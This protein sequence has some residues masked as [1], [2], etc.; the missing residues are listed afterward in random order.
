[1]IAAHGSFPRPAT[2]SPARRGI[3]RC[4]L[5]ALALLPCAA[6]AAP[7]GSPTPPPTPE[8][9]TAGYRLEPLPAGRPLRVGRWLEEVALLITDDERAR[10][11]ALAGDRQREAFVDDFW[12]R[13][14]PTPFT[15]DNE[16]RSRWTERVGAARRWAASAGVA[17][18]SDPRAEALLLAGR[19]RRIFELPCSD[20]AGQFPLQPLEI[21]Y[22][23][24]RRYRGPG[25]EPF[26]LVFILPSPAPGPP[27]A[28]R[29]EADSE[30]EAGSGPGHVRLWSPREGLAALL[31][32]RHRS[33]F[34]TDFLS[35]RAIADSADSGL[36]Y[37]GH[38][39][40]F[41][42]LERALHEGYDR[43]Q[44]LAL[45]ALPK[46]REAPA[47]GTIPTLAALPGTVDVAFAGEREEQTVVE[48]RLEL[49]RS[50][51]A[52]L[53]GREPLQHLTLT[54][55]L[56][57]DDAP[58]SHFLY[59]AYVSRSLLT[60]GDPQ[61]GE[62]GERGD[63]ATLPFLFYRTL[64]PGH[65][66]LKL[67][68]QEVESGTR[69]RS[70]YALWVPDLAAGSAAQRLPSPAGERRATLLSEDRPALVLR[71]ESLEILP[72]PPGLHLGTLAL[73]AAVTGRR[74]SYL[75][76]RLNGRPVGGHDEFP[77]GV[78]L[79]LGRRPRDHRVEAT[80]FD[81]AGQPVAYDR[82]EINAGPHRLR[83]RLI[84][85]QAGVRYEQTAPARVRVEVPDGATLDRVDLYLDD[86][87]VATS[88]TPPF[89]SE[90]PIPAPGYV[91]M[92][93]AVARLAD[94]RSADDGVLINSIEA[95]EEVEVDLV[96]LFLSAR[97]ELDQPVTDLVADDVAVF[98]D[99]IEQKVLRFERV[100]SL[101]LHVAVLMDTS[102]SMRQRLAGASEAARRF[103]ETMVNAK[104]RAALLTFN[105]EHE[106]VVPF[107]HDTARLEAGLGDIVATGSTALYDSL[108]N[109]LFYFGGLEGKRAL[110]LL[111]DGAEEN[112][113]MSYGGA[114]EFAR[115]AGV[116]IYS[117]AIDEGAG[118][119]S[120]VTRRSATLMNRLTALARQS[121]GQAF[122]IAD[123][124][125]LDA[126]Y[127]QIQRDL[128]SQY[129][130]AYQ[131]SQGSSGPRFRS[132]EIRVKHPGVRA[133][134]QRGYY[135]D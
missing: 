78:D 79:D 110:V 85:P 64:P 42:A 26:Y 11:L 90:L 87:L 126:I 123:I 24:S 77:F 61:G 1:V 36:C 55:E 131:S 54:G 50:A 56:F 112:S 52:A 63:P 97:G 29:P 16:L 48:A 45:G 120:R 13:R 53:A 73:R 60:A 40:E 15:P 51:L 71:R 23:Q 57:E 121:G 32:P 99:G 21:W 19:P 6:A 9:R 41:Q 25:E 17:D 95:S 82:L 119:P 5:L 47:A 124:A 109:A 37:R 105:H 31:Y 14:D 34:S 44:L 83:V 22:Y 88:R 94:G 38:Q 69:F 135:A 80:A 128:R 101:P 10:F 113:L 46:P 75:A 27:V 67:T 116:A 76:W 58:H 134:T 117:I 89:L 39:Q 86:A 106:L 104:D 127:A 107:T 74:I 130:V 30:P 100:E 118:A 35:L 114:L 68:L 98:E 66:T 92:V 133:S 129:L 70:S 49:S 33:R 4:A 59:R 102:E 18:L 72:P 103:F 2:L 43:S 20:P 62:G 115:R 3:L 84:E 91:G 132:V 8:Q 65:Y 111:T 125:E 81:D 12:R 93:R 28:A 122:A 108:V 7:E 96:E